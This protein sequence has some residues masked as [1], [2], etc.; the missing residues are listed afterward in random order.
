MARGRGNYRR[1]DDDRGGRAARDRRERER[2]RRRDRELHRDLD[3][4]R[5]WDHEQERRAD[6]SLDRELHRDRRR[7]DERERRLDR[8]TRRDIG[9]DRQY[10]RATRRTRTGGSGAPVAIGLVL[11]LA[12]L[13]ALLG[14]LVLMR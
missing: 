2:D 10:A 14:W 1:N 6:R 5:R 8:E 11:F 7:E 3:R 9:R 4:D 13:L 12:G